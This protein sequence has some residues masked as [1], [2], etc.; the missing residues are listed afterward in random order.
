VVRNPQSAWDWHRR[1]AEGGYF[2]AQFNFAT[3]LAGEGRMD[4]ALDWFDQACRGA[5]PESLPGMVEALIRHG[6][7]RLAA[8]AGE[9]GHALEAA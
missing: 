5:T 7:P 4:E 1:A 2:R 6:D 9:I 8:F 3:L